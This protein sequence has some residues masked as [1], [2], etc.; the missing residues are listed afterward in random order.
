MAMYVAVADGAGV[1]RAAPG[2]HDPE[3][4]PQGV[5]GPEGVHLPAAA[6]G[7]PGDRHDARSRPPRCRAG[8]RSRSRGYHIREAGSTAAQELAFTLANGFA[9]VEAATAAGLEVDEFAPRLSFFFNGHID[10]FEEIG[11]LRAARR[12]WARWMRERYGARDERIAAAALP[13]PD[14]RR[15]AHRASS[16][17]STSPGSRCRRW[18]R[19]WAARSR[20]TPT[21]STR[22]WRCRRDRAA[23]IALRTQQVVAH[24]TGV[25]NVAD[26]LGGSPYVEWMTDEMERQAEEVF[27][28]LLE[29]GDGLDAR[30]RLR[31]HRERLLREARSPTRR[32]ASSASVNAGRRIV[33]GVN[34]FTDGDDDA[35][36]TPCASTPTPRTSQ[37]GAPRRGQA[38]P[39]RP[40]PSTAR[41][42]RIGTARPRTRPPT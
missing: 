15:V 38:R 37:L 9:Y 28:H 19:C 21:P 34:A 14:R 23:R 26:P 25:A 39:R 36:A 29:L 1:A 16:P 27:A 13:H 33:V 6:L 32:T 2:R 30:G 18:P 40:R 12:I 8:T 5:P 35:P 4:H 24:E 7:A 11:K 41:W 3:R 42:Q 10:F 22:R 20:C 17:R 31:R